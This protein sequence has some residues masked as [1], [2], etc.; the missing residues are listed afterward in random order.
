MLDNLLDAV[1]VFEEDGIIFS[2]NKSACEFFGYSLDEATELNFSSLLVASDSEKFSELLETYRNTGIATR[3]GS[4]HDVNMRRKNGEIFPMRL[5]LSALPVNQNGCGMFVASGQDLTELKLQEERLRQSQRMDALGKL[6]SGI[7]HD[8]NNMLGVILGYAEI[9]LDAQKGNPVL[10]NYT[11]EI[12]KAGERGAELTQKLLAFSRKKQVKS[13]PV[14]LN[15]LL[16]AQQFMLDKTLTAKIDVSLEL[17]PDLWPVNIDAGDFQDAIFNLSINAKHAMEAGGTLSL[18]TTN[19][20][21]EESEA[22]LMQLPE[23]PYVVLEV[24]DNGVGMD[25]HILTHIFEPFFSTKGELGTGLGLSQVY[26]FVERAGGAIDVQSEVGKGSLFQFYFPRSTHDI[27]DN[28]NPQSL[29][30]TIEL[31]GTETVLVVDD[32]AALRRLCQEVLEINGYNVLCAASGEEALEILS[33]H[34]VQL[35][36]SDVVMTGIDGYQ[37][38]G[39]IHD[40]YPDIIVQLISGYSDGR[41]LQIPADHSHPQRLSK[42]IKSKLL[43]QRIR[44]L[45]NESL[46][47]QVV[48]GGGAIDQGVDGSLVDDRLAVKHSKVAATKS[49]AGWDE[50]RMESGA[51]VID[52]DHIVM[53]RYLSDLNN[54]ISAGA[55]NDEV[56]IAFQSF[57]DLI[58]LHLHREKTIVDVSRYPRLSRI[59]KLHEFQRRQAERKFSEYRG[60][61]ITSQKLYE[62]LEGWLADHVM[63][64]EQQVAPYVQ[65]RDAEIGEAISTMAFPA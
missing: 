60:G 50:V 39:L 54:N 56:L 64:T 46:E 59:E 5:S 12:Q 30:G 32:E 44:S 34:P 26:G 63:S 22:E 31:R 23:G 65:E 10:C 4:S 28:V 3:L 29:N 49:R 42:P 33:R 25:D 13:K 8:Y 24:F 61:I 16:E 37:L 51:A 38:S 35:V 20:I 45:L 53:F 47:R 62:F 36:L 9:L 48:N 11:R 21:L 27:D 52:Q 58:F 19:Q 1:I 18:R 15:V 17:C 7:A 55:S 2:F 57:I 41:N 40:K 6:T 14:D 43:L